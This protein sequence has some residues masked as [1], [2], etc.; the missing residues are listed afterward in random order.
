METPRHS[1]LVVKANK[2]IEAAYR[3]TLAEQRLLLAVIAQI[4]SRP[5][6]DSVQD[7]KFEVS[8]SQ[9]TDL[10][11]IPLKQSYE[12]MR[13]AAER[14]AER[15]VVIQHPDPD[16]PALAYT[17][18]RWIS[19][20]DYLPT[21]GRIR[22]YLATKIMPYLTQL[23]GEFARYKLKH[24]SSMTSI[25]AIR[26]YELLIQWQMQGEREV[27]VDWLRERF[28]VPEKYSRIYDLKRRVVEP[29]VEQIN[30]HSNLWVRWS[31]RKVGRVVVAFQFQF[32]LKANQTPI[33]VPASDSV[34]RAPTRSEIERAARPGESW[35]DVRVRLM[36][37]R[38]EAK[39]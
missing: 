31:Q 17:R 11:D 23:A 37:E 6:G 16:I 25:Y 4:D 36:Q 26:L 10:Y 13:D 39:K 27:A 1:Y 15:W 24:V 12:L 19:A 7:V 33:A 32:G 5:T 35:D 8:A 21:E 28:V 29:A 2:L 3:L 18:T 38:D 9:I 14:I 34:A 22:L 30:A 20:I